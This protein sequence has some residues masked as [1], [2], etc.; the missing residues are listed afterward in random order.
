MQIRD[1]VGVGITATS[2]CSFIIGRETDLPTD[3]PR[4]PASE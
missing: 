2:Y 4:D 1:N 3:H